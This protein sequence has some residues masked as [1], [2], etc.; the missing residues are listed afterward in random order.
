GAVERLRCEYA[1][2]GGERQ[3]GEAALGDGGRM[4]R[5]PRRLPNGGARNLE[6]DGDLGELC[7]DCLMLDD[8]TPALHAQLRVVERGLVGGAADAEIER[9]ILPDASARVGEERS[10]RSETILGR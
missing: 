9:R 6:P 4:V 5:R 7:P 3:I 10:V 1:G 2:D 8:G